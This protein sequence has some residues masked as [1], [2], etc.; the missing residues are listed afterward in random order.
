[1]LSW[2]ICTYRLFQ[3]NPRSLARCLKTNYTYDQSVVAFDTKSNQA[4]PAW[5]SIRAEKSGGKHQRNSAAILSTLNYGLPIARSKLLDTR[6][7]FSCEIRPSQ[8]LPLLQKQLNTP[9]YC[10]A[11]GRIVKEHKFVLSFSECLQKLFTYNR[12]TGNKCWRRFRS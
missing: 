1:M 9:G 3:S 11:T 10:I 4:R 8:A 2:T 5:R 12:Q 7:R 6:S